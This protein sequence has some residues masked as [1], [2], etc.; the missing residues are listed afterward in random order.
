[1][2]ITMFVYIFALYAL[3]T[4]GVFI[5]TQKLYGSLL[6]GVL[7]VIILYFTFPLVNNLAV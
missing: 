2:N 1:M 4:P 7:F 3:L 5:Q 6:H